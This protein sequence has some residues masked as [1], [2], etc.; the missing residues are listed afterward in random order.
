MEYLHGVHPNIHILGVFTEK[1]YIILLECYVACILITTMSHVKIRQNKPW[2][3]YL[4][5]HEGCSTVS[6]KTAFKCFTGSN[7]VLK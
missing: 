6:R 2:L 5:G 7:L 3:F 1:P 4:I